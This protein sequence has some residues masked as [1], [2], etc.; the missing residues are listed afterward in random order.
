MKKIIIT[1]LTTTLVLT[2]LADDKGLK[3]IFDGKP[4]KAGTEIQN[5]GA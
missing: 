4:S 3:S 2:T 5:F 1:F